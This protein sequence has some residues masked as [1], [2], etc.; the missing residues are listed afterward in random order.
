MPN[1]GTSAGTPVRMRIPYSDASSPNDISFQTRDAPIRGGEQYGSHTNREEHEAERDQP[2]IAHRLPALRLPVLGLGQPAP[3]Q[4][5]G[6]HVRQI[7]LDVE[8]WRAVEHVE[9][10]H[11]Q[12]APSRR[13][14]S[15]TDRPIG[16]GRSA[17]A[18]RTRHAAGRRSAA[19]PGARTLPIDRTPRSRKGARTLRCR[20]GRLRTRAGRRNAFGIVLAPNPLGTSAVR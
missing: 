17:I 10:A 3:P 4:C 12:T 7:R 8:D 15:T 1:N 2:Q 20:S 11:V 13:S 9:A 16:L 6:R 14:S 19:C 5:V 18:W